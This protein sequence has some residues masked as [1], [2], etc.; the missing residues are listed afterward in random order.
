MTQRG[1]ASNQARL[2]RIRRC[3]V[4]VLA[5]TVVAWPA[6]EITA[7]GLPF[8]MDA[9]RFGTLFRLPLYGVKRTLMRGL[10]QIKYYLVGH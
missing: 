6:G 3:S 8:G 10:R 4:A 5:V 7:S 1:L 9:D 2:T